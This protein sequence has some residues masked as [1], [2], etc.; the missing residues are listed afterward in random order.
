MT[1]DLHDRFKAVHVFQGSSFKDVRRRGKKI[2]FE[3]DNGQLIES[4][5]AMTGAWIVRDLKDQEGRLV[6]IGSHDRA[7]VFLDEGKVLVYRDVR[8]FGTLRA[9]EPDPDFS[10]L[11]PDALG[12]C[13]EMDTLVESLDS[14]EEIK[15]WLMDQRNIAGVGNIYASEVL[16]YAGLHP[17]EPAWKILKQGRH[18]SLFEDLAS[19]LRTSIA[20]GGCSISDYVGVDGKKGSFQE[21]L[22]VYGRAGQKCCVDCDETILKIVQ[23]KRSTFFCLSCQ[24]RLD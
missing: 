21:H 3:M 24:P 12:A 23:K 7:M 2:L 1:T 10:D 11:G 19:I 22:R 4:H 6:P 5:L 8:K 20:L 17:Q 14:S 18:I 9:L 13:K 15:N 16:W